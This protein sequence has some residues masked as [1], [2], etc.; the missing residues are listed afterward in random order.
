MERYCPIHSAIHLQGFQAD[1]ALLPRIPDVFDA[2]HG[3]WH[4]PRVY[5]GCGHELL[6]NISYPWS[7]ERPG[8]SEAR[9]ARKDAHREERDT[10]WHAEEHKSHFQA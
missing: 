5:F 9:E 7:V 1:R 3:P 10:A 2:V 4:S 8:N 6:C